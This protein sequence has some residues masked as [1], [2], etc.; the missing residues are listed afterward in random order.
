MCSRIGNS[1]RYATRSRMRGVCRTHARRR[2]FTRLKPDAGSVRSLLYVRRADRDAR[3]LGGGASAAVRGRVHRPLLRGPGHLAV[4][5]DEP[6]DRAAGGEACGLRPRADPRNGVHGHDG[7][8]QR[9]RPPAPLGRPAC[10]PRRR[11]ADVLRR[12]PRQPRR[13][14]GGARR[15]ALPPVERAAVSARRARGRVAARGRRRRRTPPLH[16]D[17]R[18]ERRRGSR[19]RTTRGL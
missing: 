19:I 2:P 3:G 16:A 4:H 10:P 5:G 12:P 14:R 13:R 6:R 8:A 15:R 11:H 9:P 1:A 18:S 17:A 7:G